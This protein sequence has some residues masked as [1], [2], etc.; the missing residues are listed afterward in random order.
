MNLGD[1]GHCVY[2]NIVLGFSG[3]GS[4]R[5]CTMDEEYG[6]AIMAT[7]QGVRVY[8]LYLPIPMKQA[9]HAIHI[10]SAMAICHPKIEQIPAIS[11]FIL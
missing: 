1:G 3:I 6:M 5:P 7:L 2:Y 8:I 10:R 4:A 11:G 9:G